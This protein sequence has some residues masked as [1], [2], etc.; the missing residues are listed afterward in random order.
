[1][2]HLSR[3]AP[4]TDDMSL[5]QTKANRPDLTGSGFVGFPLYCTGR[6]RQ[7]TLYCV[8]RIPEAGLLKRSPFC[9]HLKHGFFHQN[10][11]TPPFTGQCSGI[12]WAAE[13]RED[14]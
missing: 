7:I 1:M 13:F 4:D 2:T 3:H 11:G 6:E 5:L 12:M 10:K 8:S 9:N 14:H